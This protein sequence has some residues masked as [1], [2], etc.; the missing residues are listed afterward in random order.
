MMSKELKNEKETTKINKDL[1]NIFL[2]KEYLKQHKVIY[3]KQDFW[4]YKKD[5]YEQISEMD[6]YIRKFLI[7][8]KDIFNNNKISN[9]RENM[10][11]FSLIETDER[12]TDMPFILNNNEVNIHSIPF[13][14]G[15]LAVE[16]QLL[17]GKLV[18]ELTL[19]EHTS[20]FVNSYCLPYEFKTDAKD[21]EHFIKF[22]NEVYEDDKEKIGLLQEIL[23]YSLLKHNKMRKMFCFTG[24]RTGGKGVITQ[25][26]K[27]LNGAQSYWGGG[28]AQFTNTHGLSPLHNKQIGIIGEGDIPMVGNDKQTIIDVLKRITGGDPIEINRKYKEQF[29]TPKMPIKFFFCSNGLP[30]FLD[31]SGALAGRCLILPHKISFY[32]KENFNLLDELKEEIEAICLWSVKGLKRLIDNNWKFTFVASCQEVQDEMRKDCSEPLQFIEEC[33]CIKKDL[34]PEGLNNI[35]TTDND[36]GISTKDLYDMYLMWSTKPNKL[37][38]RQLVKDIKIIIPKLGN[39]KRKREYDINKDWSIFITYYDGISLLPKLLEDKNLKDEVNDILDKQYVV[40]VKDD[41]LL[42]E[43]DVL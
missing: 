13:L 30:T 36:Y 27:E 28:L 15:L 14:N 38:M 31:H 6:A 17:N 24:V 41:P 4:Q 23:G 1:E 42:I 21:P 20:D 25:I 29:Q 2:A 19:K 22:L 34:L 10:K 7:S 3:W 8:R 40:G 35:E 33:L 5:H 11:A 26:I 16:E 12:T 37:N 39:G 43:G 18:S 32:G 9:I